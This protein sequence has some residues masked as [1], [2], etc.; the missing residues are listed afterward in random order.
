[1][2]ALRLACRAHASPLYDAYVS[3]YARN[4]QIIANNTHAANP[5]Q[6]SAIYDPGLVTNVSE[7]T[8]NTSL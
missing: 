3:K 6:N 1:M 2:Y 5:K 7:I 4:T 8:G